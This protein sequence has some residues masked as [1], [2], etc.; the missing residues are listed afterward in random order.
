MLQPSTMTR[1]R[2]TRILVDGDPRLAARIC[3]EVEALCELHLISGPHQV[4]VMNKVRETAQN[5]LFYLGEALLTECKVGISLEACANA[6]A[7][8]PEVATAAATAAGAGVAAG[9]AQQAVGIG[10]ILG[11]DRDRA[12][13]LA[14]VDAAFSL[15]EPLP[16][17]L[18]AA[19]QSQWLLLLVAEEQR[20]AALRQQQR[21]KLEK[22]R[23]RF[24]SMLTEDD[25]K[26]GENG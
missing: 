9:V 17:P 11:A 2:R 1:Q 23:V 20:L 19:A 8:E 7:P 3:S 22:T 13:E 25:I 10:L 15:P 24:E 5:S 12:Y 26:D 16:P 6:G 18:S 14:V 4:L 21:D